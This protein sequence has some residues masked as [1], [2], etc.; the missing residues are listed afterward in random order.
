MGVQTSI[1]TRCLDV[2][3]KCTQESHDYFN[4]FYIW[5]FFGFFLYA[6]NEFVSGIEH[7]KWVVQGRPQ[8]SL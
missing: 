2:Y 8:R 7:T 6:K 3:G 5:T 4:V 1:L